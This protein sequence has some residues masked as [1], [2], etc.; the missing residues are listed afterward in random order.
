M[1]G[2]GFTDNI[3]VI[4][5]LLLVI[6]MTWLLLRRRVGQAASTLQRKRADKGKVKCYHNQSGSLGFEDWERCRNKAGWVTPHGYFCDEHQ[7]RNSRVVLTNGSK[8]RTHWAHQLNW[9]KKGTD[10]WTT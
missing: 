2:L 4:L 1:T 5:V 10:V 3:V 7:E 8:S 9:R 6:G